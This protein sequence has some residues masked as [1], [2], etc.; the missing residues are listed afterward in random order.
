[1]NQPW[2]SIILPTVGR[3]GLERALRSITCQPAMGIEILVVEDTLSGTQPHVKVLAAQYGALYVGHAGAE[4]CWGH[5]Q[6]NAGMEAAT[7]R[8]LA[9]MADDDIYTQLSV[10]A[11][12]RQVVRQEASGD[13]CP[14]LFRVKMNQYRTLVWG[15]P[16]HIMIGN[17]DAECI[18]TPNDPARLGRWAM[19]YTG[20][21]DFI[22]DTVESFGRCRWVEDVIAIARPTDHEDWTR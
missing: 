12:A 8:W 18:V 16:G 15:A 9:W 19:E 10:D 14:L 5:P 7:G 22:R 2:L 17:V 11:I 20:D 21:F 4:H 1:M 13:P 3:P 6:R